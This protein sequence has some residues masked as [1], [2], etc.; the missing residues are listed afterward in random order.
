MRSIKS[1]AALAGAA[2]WLGVGAVAAFADAGNSEPSVWE[3]H[4][5]NT[6]FFGLTSSFTCSGLED[7][8]KRV[9]LYFGARP[10]LKVHASCPDRVAPVT[11]AVVKTDFYSLQPASSGASDT[12]SGHWVPIDLGP[13]PQ[14]PHFMGY[15]ECELLDQFKAVLSKDFSFRGLNYHALCIPNSVSPQNFRVQGQVLKPEAQQ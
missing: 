2:L 9:L 7:T 11:S 3:H 1:L 15:S 8:V 12:V 6:S 5:A 14:H 13:G 4:E 10:D